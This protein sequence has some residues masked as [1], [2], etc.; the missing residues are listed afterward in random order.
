MYVRKDGGTELF[1]IASGPNGNDTRW[2]RKFMDTLEGGAP[3]GISL[4]YYEGGE[5]PPL[6]FTAEHVKKQLAI[7]GRVEEAIVEQRALF[8]GYRQGNKIG[9]VFDEWAY[10]R[11]PIMPFGCSKSIVARKRC[12]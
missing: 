6:H 5:D 8:D 12:K 9:L 7:F 1:R 2:S 11:R 3:E 10:A 4:H